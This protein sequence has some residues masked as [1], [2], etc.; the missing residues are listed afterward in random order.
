MSQE[1]FKLFWCR[2]MKSYLGDWNC[3]YNSESRSVRGALHA[4]RDFR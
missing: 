3:Y 1:S 4:K 2:I